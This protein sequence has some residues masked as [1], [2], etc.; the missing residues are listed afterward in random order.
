M[1]IKEN[2]EFEYVELHNITEEVIFDLKRLIQKIEH[3]DKV[4]MNTIHHKLGVMHQV[5]D[6]VD[7]L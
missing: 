6:L 7:K 3:G 5:A 2:K 4:T 1:V